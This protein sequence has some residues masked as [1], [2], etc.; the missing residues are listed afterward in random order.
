MGFDG[1][2]RTHQAQ[3]AYFVYRSLDCFPVLLFGA[4]E[5]PGQMDSSAKAVAR[6]LKLLLSHGNQL[7]EPGEVHISTEAL[8]TQ[9]YYLAITQRQAYLEM[10][11]LAY[12]LAFRGVQ[13]RGEV[14]DMKAAFER[15]LDDISDAFPISLGKRSR[16]ELQI[17]ELAKLVNDAMGCGVDGT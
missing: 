9:L 4:S 11:R 14:R 15:L 2:S 8:T 5:Q 6:L 1:D 12:D 17:K 10:L 13:G 7:P 3:L 16:E